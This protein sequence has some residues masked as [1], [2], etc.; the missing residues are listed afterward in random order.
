MAF[1]DDVRLVA[2]ILAGDAGAVEQFISEYRQFIYAILVRHLSLSS[3]DAEEVFQRFLFHIWEDDYRRLRDWR[4]KT[5]L[6]GYIARIARNL[7]HDF[8]RQSR[9]EGQECPDVARDDPRLANVER[10]EMLE[11]A[12]PLLSARDRELIHR[13]FY[14]EQTH[15]EIAE[16]FGMTASAIGVALS[17]AK[18]RLKKII[19]KKNLRGL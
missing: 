11:R 1:E 3:D 2:S 17:R 5:T 4:G 6:A 8:R 15:S 9:F 10:A 12:L 18:R 19:D 16:A 14:L 13:R 7:G